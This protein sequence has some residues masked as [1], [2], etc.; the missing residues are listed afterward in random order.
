LDTFPSGAR[1]FQNW[2][3]GVGGEVVGEGGR[4]MKLLEDSAKWRVL[5]LA[6]LFLVLSYH[7]LKYHTSRNLLLSVKMPTNM[8]HISQANKRFFGNYEP[9]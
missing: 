6:H 9:T 8:I 2:F 1:V 3:K 4:M 7:W 5:V